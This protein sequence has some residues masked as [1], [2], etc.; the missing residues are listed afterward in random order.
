L[1]DLQVLPEGSGITVWQGGSLLVEAGPPRAEGSTVQQMPSTAAKLA[2]GGPAAAALVVPDTHERLLLAAAPISFPSGQSGVVA[3]TA[4]ERNVV[5]SRVGLLR[6]LLLSG[7]IAIA[8]ALAVGFGLA[9]WLSRPLRRLSRAAQAMAGGSYGEPIT[10]TY[11]GEVYDLAESLEVM[12]REVR[13]SEAS[14]RGFVASA[15]HELRTPLTSIEGFS[16][17]LLDGTAASTDERRGASAAIYR[18]SSRLHRL[19]DSLLILSRFD[20]REY[21]PQLV[22]V[23]VGGLVREEAERLVE[24]GLA[25]SE[26]VRVMPGESV[27]AVT[28]PDMFRQVVGNLLRNAVQYGGEDLVDARV[29]VEGG[30]LVLEV[31]NGGR[32]LDAEERARVF[33]RFYRGWGASRTEGFGL[34]LP[35]VR[36]ICEVLGG[37]I[38]LMEPGPRTAFRVT[39][40]DVSLP[41]SAVPG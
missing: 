7:V 10:G 14:L 9:S 3:I 36:E 22:L 12:R 25:E 41:S 8:L 13:R 26:R 15:A 1:V 30:T 17:A 40:P 29:A 39:L 11:A 20:S 19:V 27:E 2:G 32:P 21:R 37:R 31:S 4:P 18:E 38:E 5:A 23:D 24:A 16:Q 34:G 28:D 33:E 35:L 6:V